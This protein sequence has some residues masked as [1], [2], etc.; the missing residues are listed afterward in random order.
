MPRRTLIV[1]GLIGLV[2][3]SVAVGIAIQRRAQSLAALRA[4]QTEAD[5]IADILQ[6]APGAIVAD[7]WAGDGRWSV[8]LARRLAPDGHVYVVAGPD[9]PVEDIYR[10][11]AAAE[12]DNLTIL[13]A[14]PDHALGWLQAD[15]CDALLVRAVYHDLPDRVPVTRQLFDEI[16][17]GG[18]LALIDFEPDSPQAVPGHSIPEAVVI[19]EVTGVGFEMTRTI[20]D[21]TEGTYCV[22]FEKPAS[23]ATPAVEGNSPE[24]APPG[25]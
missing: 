3:V 18:R 24:P 4:F 11:V 1:L 19:Q 21:W 9:D 13:S 25:T 16:R 20:R 15:C 12:L 17:P 22:V 5:A 6:L 7:I 10:N 8:D 23:D 14:E 2:I